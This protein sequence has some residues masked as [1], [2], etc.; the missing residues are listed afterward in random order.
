VHK[1]RELEEK[2]IALI[3]TRRYKKQL[4]SGDS[5]MSGPDGTNISIL[6]LKKLASVYKTHYL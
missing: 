2:E 4:S 5:I 3:Q 6:F 1:I